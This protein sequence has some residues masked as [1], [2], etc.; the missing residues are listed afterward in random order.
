MQIGIKL[1][2]TYLSVFLRMSGGRWRDSAGL[3]GALASRH[4]I[5]AVRHQN[6]LGEG[7]ATAKFR[8]GLELGSPPTVEERAWAKI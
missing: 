2:A 3:I 4:T 8:E 6:S 7:D 5:V 1:L